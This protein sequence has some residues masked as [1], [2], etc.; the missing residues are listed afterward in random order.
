MK[1]KKYKVG[2]ALGG[3]AAR[4]WAHFGI[5]RA[6]NEHGIK[7]DV[8]CGTSM[9]AL[10]GAAYVTQCHS[11]F[12]EWV[13]SLRKRDIAG[14]LDFTIN[15]GGLIEGDRVMKF[16]R[17]HI[18][19]NIKIENLNLSYAAVATELT[20]GNEVWFQQGELLDAV[21][22]SISLPGLFTPVYLNGRWFADGALV[23]PVPVSV[24]RALGAERVIAI[25]LNGHL[26]GKMF[27]TKK[28][29]NAVVKTKS[30][31]VNGM[32]RWVNG[33]LVNNKDHAV[34]GVIDVL[35][36]SVYIMQDRITRSRMAGN[37]PDVLLRP[38]L[39]SIGLLDFERA[40]ESID[41]GFEVVERHLPAL[42]ELYH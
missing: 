9:G 8:V 12:E 24:C 19:E 4:G 7:P 22:A 32:M 18:V 10:V 36:R 41:K 21:R 15:G 3:G 23:N 35:S 1:T 42:D 14:L 37:P 2:L 20:T 5:I 16:L 6:L 39:S 28:Q 29:P 13:L 31:A 27:N 33:T 30:M 38:D 11:R 25:D 40:A 26:Y 34:P 17:R